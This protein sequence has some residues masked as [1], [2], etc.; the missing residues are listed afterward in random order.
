MNLS[1]GNMIKRN[2]VK[3]L[4][5]IFIK[6]LGVS[7]TIILEQHL[8]SLGFSRNTFKAS[9]IDALVDNIL[10]EY[11]KILGSHINII[12]YEIEKRFS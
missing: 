9:D 5:D 6:E 8:Q 1:F 3:E 11:N 10:R 2:A 12:K 7:S 4:E